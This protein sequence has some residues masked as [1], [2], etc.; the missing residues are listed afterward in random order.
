M[1][2]AGY[3]SKYARCTGRGQGVRPGDRREQFVPP[4][5]HI[6][7]IW[8]RNDDTRGVH[9]AP[10][11]EVVR[12]AL[13]METTI[14]KAEHDLLNPDGINCIRSF[15]GRGSAS[16][17]PARSR[18][19]RRGATSTSGGSSTTSRSRSSTAPNGS[20]SSRTTTI[21]GSG[22]RGR[23][24]RSCRCGATARCSAQRRS[25][26]STSSATRRPTRRSPRRRPGDLRDRDR[27]GQAGRVRRL[28]YRPVLRRREP[29]PSK[30]KGGTWHCRSATDAL[31]DYSFSIEID[32][33]TIAQFKEVSGLNA[34]IQVIEHR[35]NRRALPLKK[36]PAPESRGY[37]A[38]SGAGPTRWPCGTG[39]SR[40]RTATCR[41]AEER[42]GHPLRLR[43]RRGSPLQ[44]HQRLAVQ[45]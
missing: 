40:S 23:S 8:G 7:G 26:R 27:A 35:E 20:S 16:G 4:S 9:K 1:E 3:D 18:A 37:H 44:L 15:P 10:A 21:S 28:P 43:T 24:P 42:L 17:A 2:K 29:S 34:E 30:R 11:N 13:D 25:R 36:L 12:G 45:V 5:G 19:T 32:G 22:M 33:V 38:P 41:G 14:T 39:S 6:A 31:A